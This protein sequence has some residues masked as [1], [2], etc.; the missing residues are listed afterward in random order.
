MSAET[1]LPV[2]PMAPVPEAPALAAR[3]RFVHRA[4]QLA[5]LG[6]GWHLIEPPSLWLLE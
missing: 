6:L 4:R 5:W 1:Q 3:A 2:L